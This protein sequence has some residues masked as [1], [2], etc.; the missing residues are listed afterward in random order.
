MQPRKRN[1]NKPENQSFRLEASH[2]PHNCG[3]VVTISGFDKTTN[4]YEMSC[5]FCHRVLGNWVFVPKSEKHRY[6]ASDILEMK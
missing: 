2:I 6:K 3:R 1:A 4:V 5:V